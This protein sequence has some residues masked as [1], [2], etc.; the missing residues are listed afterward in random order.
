MKLNIDQKFVNYI[1]HLKEQPETTM[2]H[3]A[4]KISK[5]LHS[6]NK[7]CF[8]TNATNLLGQHNM[9]IEAELRTKNDVNVFVTKTRKTYV[10]RWKNKLNNSKKLEFYKT[11]KQ[12]YNCEQYL[13]IIDDPLQRK[14]Y[15]KFRISNHNL[16]I[17]YGRYRN[18]KV[19]K[20]NRLCLVCES[21]QIKDEMHL[22]FSCNCYNERRTNMING[23]TK[24]TKQE[25]YQHN[26]E[27]YLTE[28][29]Q[30]KDPLVIRLFCNFIAKCFHERKLKLDTSI[31]K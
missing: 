19:P 2:V 23:F 27:T 3:Q 21:G 26:Q 24:I 10:E 7:N 28:I 11:L 30:S 25:P 9:T 22:I 14:D 13:N 31:R 1:L 6:K 16:M 18:T 5:Q 12:E 4:F 20:E 15:T 29:L 8:Y 17:E